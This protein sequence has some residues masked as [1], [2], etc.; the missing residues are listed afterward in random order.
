L[1]SYKCKEKVIKIIKNSIYYILFYIL[2]YIKEIKKDKF[3]LKLENISIIFRKEKEKEEI[4][5]ERKLKD[6]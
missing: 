6:Y 1:R 2:F 4:E 3:I 5:K